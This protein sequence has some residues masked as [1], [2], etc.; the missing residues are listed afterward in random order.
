MGSSDLTRQTEPS[1]ELAL[2][3]TLLKWGR[4]LRRHRLLFLLSPI[5]VLGI[6]IG[7]A[8]RIPTLY[9]STTR[10]LLSTES[11][12]LPGLPGAMSTIGQGRSAETLTMHYAQMALSQ[13]ILIEVLDEPYSDGT[14]RDHLSPGATPTA[15]LDIG[16]A[17]SL[18]G[19]YRIIP[20][21]ARKTVQISA[22]DLEADF[23]AAALWGLL[24]VMDRYLV[25]EYQGAVR[26]HRELIE[27]NIEYV[28]RKLE[29]AE[30]ALDAFDAEHGE[31]RLTREE[32]DEREKL[33]LAA[34][35]LPM[36]LQETT[37]LL[38]LT[39]I[40]EAKATTPVTILEPPWIPLRKSSAPRVKAV[41]ALLLIGLLGVGFFAYG[42]DAVAKYRDSIRP[43]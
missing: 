27:S 30:A 4:F 1:I 29:A 28:G 9:T 10:I 8:S 24:H 17:R 16:L 21:P 33:A 32:A 36:L 43:Q 15:A 37:Q 7:L 3:A 25:E 12:V 13:T 6:G 18:R 23:T 2:A 5:I 11:A 38:L 20:D 14:I 26:H 40:S 39:Q 19:C 42:R 22:Q 34:R 31:N 41:V 35:S